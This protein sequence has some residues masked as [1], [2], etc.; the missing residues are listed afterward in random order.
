MIWIY[1]N[2]WLDFFVYHGKTGILS[3][4]WHFPPRIGGSGKCCVARGFGVRPL[5]ALGTFTRT[6]QGSLSL[7][8]CLT[9]NKVPVWVPC[10]RWRKDR[11][12]NPG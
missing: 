2:D 3:A 12:S 1:Y 8:F 11:D 10:L 6:R 7:S 5:S 9:Q 4:F